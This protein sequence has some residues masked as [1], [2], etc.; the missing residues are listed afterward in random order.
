MTVAVVGV[1]ESD[2]GVTGKSILHLQTQAIT[3]ALA[4][5]GL[6]LRDVDGLATAGVSRFSTPQVAEY[7]GIQPAWTDSTFAGGSAFEMYVA[8]AVQAIEAGQCTTVL[9][10]YGSDQRSA[11]SRSLAGA[12]ETH[13]PQAQ[14]ETPYGPLFPLSYYAMAAQRYLHDRGASRA[15]LAEVAVAAR[16]QALLNPKAFRHRAGPLTVEDVL[17]Q[18]MISSPLTAADCC[19]ITDGG[20]AIVLTSLER[21]RDLRADPVVV[22]GYGESTTHHGMAGAADLLRTGSIDSGRRAFARA[23]LGPQDVDVAQLYDS[24][25]ITVLLTLEGLGFCGPGE[26]G[27]FVRRRAL[28]FN[29]TGG[30]LSYCHPGMLGLLLLVEAVRQLRGE[31][32]PRQVPGAEVAL[33]HGVGGIFST[34]ATVLLG[35]D[36]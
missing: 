23:G 31:C 30:G 25:T 20:G 36:R 10:S 3:R 2:L 8:R 19:L 11:R 14:F 16:E 5:A 24:F 7:L 6:S 21:A 22:L 4:D 34:H 32:G 17:G 26:A 28:P 13:T 27:D 35:A 29:T 18:P 33:A 15:D 9:I 12:L 1:A